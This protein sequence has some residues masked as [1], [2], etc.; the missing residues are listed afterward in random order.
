MIEMDL[1]T[2]LKAARMKHGASV[3]NGNL[4][5]VNELV[6]FVNQTTEI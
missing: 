6:K 5:N 1:A 2:N 3:G 4:Q